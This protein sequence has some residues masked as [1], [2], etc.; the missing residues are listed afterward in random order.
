[1][2]Y[3]KTVYIEWYLKDHPDCKSI[4]CLMLSMKDREHCFKIWRKQTI[5]MD[6]DRLAI[7]GLKTYLE[8]VCPESKFVLHKIRYSNVNRK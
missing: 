7:D 2:G 5:Y 8:F 3:N 1:M 6:R 4:K